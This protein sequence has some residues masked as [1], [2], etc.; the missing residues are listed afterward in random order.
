MSE[1]P[2]PTPALQRYI[3]E[4]NAHSGPPDVRWDEHEKATIDKALSVC[5]LLRQMPP[6]EPYPIWVVS[7][8]AT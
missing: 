2:D 4:I 7:R 3:A 5:E 1:I 6:I 8:A